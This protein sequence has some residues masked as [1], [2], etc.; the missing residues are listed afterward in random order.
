[1]LFSLF[2]PFLIDWVVDFTHGTVKWSPDQKGH[3]ARHESERRRSRHR[4]GDADDAR[5][6]AT[7]LSA[8]C[9]IELVAE[10]ASLLE[11]HIL[12]D[13]ASP[14][15][16]FVAPRRATEPGGGALVDGSD[17]EVVAVAHDPD[18]HGVSQRA[19]TS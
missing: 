6:V 16:T 5:W 9:D 2:L 4:A 11:A 13:A 19:V 10:F 1:Q 7:V 15:P 18:R 12:L 14:D 17:V 3:S 8:V